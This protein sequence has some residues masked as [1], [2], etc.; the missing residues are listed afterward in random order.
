MSY[1]NRSFPV[2]RD[3]YHSAVDFGAQIGARLA[4]VEWIPAPANDIGPG[5][6][7][8]LSAPDAPDGGVGASVTQKQMISLGVL[9]VGGALAAY[10]F[11]TKA[12][13]AGTLVLGGTLAV[14]ALIEGHNSE[15]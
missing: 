8:L 1:L 12:M 9:G 3:T 13:I 5:S 10:L 7:G 6:G 11:I 14:G 4:G 2:R 15:A